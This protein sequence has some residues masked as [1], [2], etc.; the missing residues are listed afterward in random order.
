ME[1][2]LVDQKVFVTYNRYTWRIFCLTIVMH[3]SLLALLLIS[4]LY[5]SSTKVPQM[6]FL[7]VIAIICLVLEV[8]EIKK[9]KILK[10]H[11]NHLSYQS[12][13]I[14]PS[15][16]KEIVFMKG[17]IDIRKKDGK[18]SELLLRLSLRDKKERN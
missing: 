9:I 4:L 13:M 3:A 15:N 12:E 2:K 17:N 18:L 14:I 16:I 6:F 8:I 11:N 1:E 10:V 5:D 7:G